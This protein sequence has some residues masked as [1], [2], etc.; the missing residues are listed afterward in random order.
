MERLR[1]A[2]LRNEP[3]FR[4]RSKD[5]VERTYVR[6][7][8]SLN[9]NAKPQPVYSLQGGGGRRSPRMSPR[10]SQR[11]SPR[12][13]WR[14]GGG[15]KSSKKKEKK[16]KKKSKKLKKRIRE[17]ELQSERA[18][19]ERERQNMEDERARSATPGGMVN[20]ALKFFGR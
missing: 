18:A 17:M 1:E 6:S 16:S 5:G 4:Y 20:S 9:E 13:S 11:R 12:R 2:K 15:F 8:W 7:M 10:M 19:V 14:L 3:S